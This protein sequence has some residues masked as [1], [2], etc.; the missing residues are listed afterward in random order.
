MCLL[1]LSPAVFH[2]IF[3]LLVKLWFTG[4]YTHTPL[5]IKCVYKKKYTEN[6]R[7]LFIIAPW[8]IKDGT[9]CEKV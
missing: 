2:S 8:E 5:C 7:L 4:R 1:I 9:L 3:F 6:Q